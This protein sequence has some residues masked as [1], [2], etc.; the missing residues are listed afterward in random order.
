MKNGLSFN[1][2]VIIVFALQLILTSNTFAQK[3]ATIPWTINT[4]LYSEEVKDTFLI[5]VALP[6]SYDETREYPVVYIT[7]ARFGFGT[8]V[9]IS[10]ANVI[11]GTTSPAIIVGIGYP[12]DQNFGRIMQIRSRDFSTVSD[13][14]VPG[15]WPAWAAEIE[16]GGAD[17]FLKFID[18]ELIPYV[19]DNYQVNNDRTYMGW[20]GGGLFG[21]Y[22]MFN[23][24]DLFNNY[25]LVSSPYEWFHNGI[26]FE[27]E[28]NYAGN[29]D[30][31]DLNVILAV[32]TGDSESTIESNR[33]M[34]KILS[35]RNYEGL[36]VNFKIFENKKH[37]AVWPT[38]IIHGL[39]K[40]LDSDMN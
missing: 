37:Y 24:P 9:E 34:S 22:L 18:K 5:S 38:A 19:E 4:E 14:Q 21:T 3:N 28:D 7:D 33:R 29:N 25:L 31:L 16:W 26:A 35:D 2:K 39:P 17:A 12:G 40:I 6:E 20:S 1:H 30:T 15:G 36:N 13:P 10:R 27:Y 8:A 32:G 23:R 11:D